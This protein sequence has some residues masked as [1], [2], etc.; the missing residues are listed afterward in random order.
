MFSLRLLGQPI[1]TVAG[2]QTNELVRKRARR[3]D[4]GR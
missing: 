3:Q 1:E 4:I 2:R